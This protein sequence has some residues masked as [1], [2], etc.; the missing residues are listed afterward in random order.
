MSVFGQNSP[1]VANSDL[2]QDGI[3]NTQ[4][5]LD[6]L[7]EI[8]VSQPP[9]NL[10]DA[11]N[12]AITANVD[13]NGNNPG[14]ILNIFPHRDANVDVSTEIVNNSGTVELLEM[15]VV[16]DTT[17]RLRGVNI[18]AG[19]ND[20]VAYVLNYN[21]TVFNPEFIFSGIDQGDIVTVTAFGPGNQIIS[22]TDLTN[23]GPISVFFDGVFDGNDSGTAND[24]NFTLNPNGA[25]TF[26]IQNNNST[27][28][29]IISFTAGASFE[30]STNPDNSR[31]FTTVRVDGLVD[32]IVVTT[33]KS[34]RDGDVVNNAFVTFGLTAHAYCVIQDTDNDETPDHLDL[35]SDNDGCPDE[36]DANPTIASRITFSAG[37]GFPIET[38]NQGEIGAFR[39]DDSTLETT[40]D[41]TNGQPNFNGPSATSTIADIAFAWYIGGRPDE[42][43]IRLTEDNDVNDIYR[44][45]NSRTLSINTANSP[46]SLDGEDFCVVITHPDYGC[47]DVIQCGVLNI[48][49]PINDGD[50]N[51]ST[52]ENTTLT[53]DLFN[54]TANNAFNPQIDSATIDLDG[55][56]V[57][58]NL[59]IGQ[60]TQITNNSGD[61]IGTFL[62]NDNGTFTFDPA[63]GFTGSVPPI[64]YNI[65]NDN[66][67]EDSSTLNI[68]V[69]P[70]NINL[71]DTD[72]DGI[73]DVSD[74]DDDNDGILDVVENADCIVFNEDFG[75]GNFPGQPLVAPA[76]T[77][78]FFRDDIVPF[79]VFPRALE[80]NQY[81]LGVFGNQPNGTWQRDIVDNTFDTVDLNFDPT[82]ANSVGGLMLIINA[83]DDPNDNND[84][85]IFYSRSDVVLDA[86]TTYNLS[87]WVINL[88]SIEDQNF[89][90]GQ[91][92]GFVIPNVRYEIRDRNN[93]GAVIASF[94]TGDIPRSGTTWQNFAFEFNSG[95]TTNV[96]VVLLNNGPGGCGNDLAL[97]DIVL[98]NVAGPSGAL[99][100]D[101]IMMVL[102]IA[103]ILMQI[104]MES[105]II[106][107]L[108]QH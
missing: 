18:D 29:S 99:C 77:N 22:L 60:S 47:E 8:P 20:E 14:E 72:G 13:G 63:N 40:T 85:Q 42:G 104:M 7:D 23:P 2:D 107:K 108:K 90:S 5:G 103:L 28:P 6:C 83:N 41:F 55:D 65:V 78:H 12:Y 70:S 105:L 58:D 52:L 69:T 49:D 86:N 46:S 64:A 17:L 19:V 66:N 35:D 79:D 91:P 32:R 45:V 62:L 30:D 48:F 73:P 44:G 75:V 26:E 36:D 24:P 25:N 76:G 98:T 3:S 106:L 27:S 95:S 61:P 100:G 39:V 67:T 59:P 53:S 31:N 92:G 21:E 93:N 10:E 96:D 57:Q 37:D 9:R 82:D 71:T 1:F 87:A 102:L 88:N 80:D 11:F 38:V 81:V 94:E 89:C 15:F 56:G 74:I 50:E 51:L 68:T 97:D 101:L 4:E 34:R 43:G 84:A 33:A 54:N 16:D